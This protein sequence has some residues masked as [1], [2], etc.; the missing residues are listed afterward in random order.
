MTLKDLYTDVILDHYKNPRNRREMKDPTHIANGHNP[1]CGDKLKLYVNVENDKI[2]DISFTGQGCA[3]HTASI[4]ILTE[5]VKGLTLDEAKELIESFI[6]MLIENGEAD[7]D[8]LG[9]LVVLQGVKELHARVRCATLPWYTL[10]LALF[11]EDVSAEDDIKG[12]EI[13]LK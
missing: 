7:E 2:A 1:L 6:G 12:L 3:I 11:G 8:K 13:R 9:E 5:K 4:S 10:D